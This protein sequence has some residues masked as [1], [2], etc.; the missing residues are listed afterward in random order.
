MSNRDLTQLERDALEAL[1]DSANLEAV[2]QG[3]SLICEEKADHIIASYSDR[4][5]AK[6]WLHAGGV[7]G[8]AACDLE[9]K[10]GGL[11]NA[12]LGITR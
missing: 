3:L 7:C 9:M 2:L 8:V 12:T 6:R 5:L 4:S 10:Q 11:P 1:I